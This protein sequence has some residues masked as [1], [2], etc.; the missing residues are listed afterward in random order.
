LLHAFYRSA[1][2][3]D[4]VG[5]QDLLLR[6]FYRSAYLDDRRDTEPL[7]HVFISKRIP[8]RLSG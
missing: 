8:T 6:F 5:T 7:L 3:D 2:L 4:T 1:Y